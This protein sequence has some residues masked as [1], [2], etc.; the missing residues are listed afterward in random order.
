MYDKIVH[1]NRSLLQN[2]ITSVRN[3]HTVDFLDIS[4]DFK[5]LSTRIFFNP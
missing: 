1:L 4:V 5:L 3:Y 2:R